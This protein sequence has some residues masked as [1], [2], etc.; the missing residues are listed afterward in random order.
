MT[1]NMDEIVVM[2]TRYPTPGQAKTR[3]IEALGPAGAAGMHRLLTE[4]V[5]AAV[6]S[7]SRP[8]PEIWYTGASRKEMFDWLGDQYRFHRQKEGDLGEKMGDA[9]ACHLGRGNMCC[10]I[11][12]DS[13]GLDNG[14]IDQAFSSLGRVDV[15]LGPSYDGGYYLIGAAAGLDTSFVASL[16]SG[17]SWGSDTVLAETITRIRRGDK[18]YHLLPHLH[19]IDTPEDLRHLH[20]YRRP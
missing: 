3:L 17:V 14:I 19:D 18:S 1:M 6:N 4:R 9:L 11:G 12:A 10:L 5:L 15:V 2:L 16:F 7:P 20:H 8:A 13:P